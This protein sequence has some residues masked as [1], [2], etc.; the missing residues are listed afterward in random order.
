MKKHFVLE[1]TMLNLPGKKAW[2][3]KVLIPMTTAHITR[4]CHDLKGT[5]HRALSATLDTALFYRNQCRVEFIYL[6]LKA[7][8][9]L[10][11]Q[12]TTLKRWS[13]TSTSKNSSQLMNGR[14]W[15]RLSAILNKV[16]LTGME[17]IWCRSSFNSV[18]RWWSWLKRRLTRRS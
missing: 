17:L 2:V 6:I 14:P 3:G 16:S 13:L 11:V 10:Q 4:H 12:K 1:L 9:T 5:I 15:I 8:R 18:M 7:N